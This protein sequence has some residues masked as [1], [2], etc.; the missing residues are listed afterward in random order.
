MWTSNIAEVDITTALGRRLVVDFLVDLENS[1][2]RR[3]DFQV[4]RGTKPSLPAGT[5]GVTVRAS[6]F[7]KAI[8]TLE[9]LA[10]L[11]QALP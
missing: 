4:E 7:W 3:R 1:F 9:T 5:A 10:Q 11:L 6:A 2:T 8:A